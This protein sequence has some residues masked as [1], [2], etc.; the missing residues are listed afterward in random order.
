MSNKKTKKIL[1]IIPAR[2]GSK[3]V[4]RKN[5]RYLADKP[6]IAWTIEE[7]KKSKYID[8]LILSSE[9]QEIISVASRYDCEV[10]FIRPQ[11]L[12]EDNTPGINPVIHALNELPGYDVVVLLQ[13][14]SPLRT[15]EDIDGCIETL[16]NSSAPSCV[17]VT[18]ADKSPYWMYRIEDEE[19]M[20][21]LFRNAASLR[22]EL[23][24]VYSL[25]GAVYAADT[26]WIVEFSQFIKE[27]TVPY[28]MP[29]ERSYDIDTEQDFMITDYLLRERGKLND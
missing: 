24:N 16:L 14:T 15:V 19:V 23:P 6:L 17:T 18:E 5:I 2:G 3:G 21:P 26:N 22:Q 25:N 28:I 27:K 8:R 20:I 10:P 11:T 13:P 29:K 4:P 12:A 7:A 1:A 9:D